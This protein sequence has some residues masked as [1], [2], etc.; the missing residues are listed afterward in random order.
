MAKKQGIKERLGQAAME[1]PGMNK[2][3][4]QI[5]KSL[6]EVRKILDKKS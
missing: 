3:L 1:T 6:S 5:N 2:K 4:I